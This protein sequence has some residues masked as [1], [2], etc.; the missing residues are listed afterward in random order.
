MKKFVWCF[1]LLMVMIQM[2]PAQLQPGVDYSNKYFWIVFQPYLENIQV[3]KINNWFRSGFN[4]TDA[5]FDRFEIKSV[6][7]EVPFAGPQDRDGNIDFRKVYRVEIEPTDGILQIIEQFGKDPAL[8]LAEAVPIYHINGVSPFIPNDNYYNYQWHLPKI[9]A[10]YAWGMWQGNTP[11]SDSIVVAILDTG[12]DWDHPDLINNIW[13][14]LG[15]DADGDGHTLEYNGGQW[16]FDPGDLNGVD[17]DDWDSN[18]TSYVDDLIGWDFCGATV[19]NFVEDNDPHSSQN[20][21]Y[22]GMLMHGTHVAGTASPTTNNNIGV[23]GPGFTAKI[24]PIKVSFDN[25]VS[26]PPGVYAGASAYLYAAKAGADVM[27]C[28]FGGPSYSGII[29]SAINTA[30]DIYGTV[31]VAAAGNDNQNIQQTPQYPSN[32]NNVI[33]VAAVNSG[34]IKAGFSN[35]GPPV[36]ISAPGV[37]IWSTVYKNVS[38]G[39]QGSGWSGTSMA[40]PVVAGSY[41]LLKAFFPGKSIPWLEQRLLNSA[42]PIDD[43]N[44]G[45]NGWLGS[46]RVNIYN[47]I[48]QGIFPN[49]IFKS[50]ALQING[51]TDGQLNPGES[52]IMRVTIKNLT[53]WNTATG[54]STVLRS[55][56]GEL[57]ITDS[58]ATYPDISSGSIGINITDVFEFTV[59]SAAHIGNIPVEM[60]VNAN[61]DSTMAYEVTL[62][63]DLEVSINQIGWPQAVD[64]LIQSSPAVV[65]LNNDGQKEVIATATDNKVY[66]WKSDGT[67]LTG[68]PVSTSNQIIAS[69]AVAD[70]DNDGTPEIAVASKGY[71][72]YI[73]ENDGSI[74]LDFNAG[75]QLWGTPSLFDF[76]NDGD[77]EIAFGDFSGKMHVIHHDGSNYGNFPADLGTN[78]RILS[79]LAVDDL[80]EDGSADIAF[81][82]FNGDVYAISSLDA[83]FLSGF[84]VNVGARV[85]SAPAIA[86][87]DGSGPLTKQLFI[88]SINNNLTLIDFQGTMTAQFGF[89]ASIESSPA[90]ADVDND[91]VSDVLF[92]CNDNQLYAVDVYGNDLPG[93]PVSTGN[94]VKGSPVVSDVD[95][96]GNPEAAFVNSGGLFFLVKNDGSIYPGFPID[97]GGYLESTPT[98]DDL[99]EDGDMELLLGGSHSLYIYDLNGSGTNA[100]F[101]FTL[102]G[103]YQ[104]TANYGDLITG[105]KL[106]YRKQFPVKYHLAPNYPNP[107]N[108]S[109]RIGYGIRERT[110]VELAIYNILGQKIRTLISGVKEPGNYE[111]IWDGRDNRGRIVSSGVYIYQ[112]KSG[113]FVQTRKMM[114]LR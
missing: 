29:Q 87:P 28:S 109:T 53:G 112:I 78:H 13:Q 18:P 106:S 100:S 4:S 104:R 101:W 32:Y 56:T 31:V 40:S 73:Y 63:F 1:A 105:L 38:G 36:D 7:R 49:I 16:E 58:T 102:Q 96:D 43:Q 81:G 3:E 92:G 44:P 62:N 59:D 21:G 107:F 66:V 67:A 84:P 39:Y 79:G 33:S 72:L 8:V 47:A 91:G 9:Q 46:G 10:D 17:D 75:T 74:S 85:E 97:V 111:V 27:N 48:A 82:T 93:F 77:L 65:D 23:A 52:A 110:K 42:D 61:Q 113:S 5:L 11:G 6:V 20:T 98:F 88:T 25:D 22:M 108:P 55:P 50:Y 12:V 45:Y 70:I 114:F 2:A 68:F 35:Y 80:D 30:H 15:E 99:D 19:G 64:G 26:G 89:P 95:G 51:D 71:H 41:A 83:G 76:D 54:I 24:L 57:N 94:N 103:N 14:N 86:D 60:Q 37:N 34:D 69:P 90:I